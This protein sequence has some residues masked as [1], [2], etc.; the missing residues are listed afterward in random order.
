MMH[1]H[2]MWAE[3]YR[4]ETLEDCIM[5]AATRKEIESIVAKGE[6][7]SL[8]FAGSAGIGKTTVAIALANAVDYDFIKINGSLDNGIDTLR[9]DIQQF[10]S[11]VSFN[12]K[13]KVVIIDEADNLSQAMQKGLRGFIDEFSANCSF[14]L[15]ANFANKIIEPLQSRLDETVTFTFSLNEKNFL[16]KS[17]FKRLTE[18]FELENVRGDPAALREFVV[19]Q[20]Q[21]KN[22]IRAII[23]KAQAI[24]RKS[25][26]E[27]NN[28][29]VVDELDE[30]FVAMRQALRRRSFDEIRTWVG[31]NS[32]IDPSDIF[33]HIYENAKDIA[34]A[35]AVPQLVLITN[36]YQYKHAFVADAELN[37]VACLVEIMA[38]CI[39]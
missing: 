32:D 26:G 37:I 39:S 15:T 23:T 12:G 1:A 35:K 8:L 29:A 3:K 9:S 31:E 21:R 13:P 16:A 4:P 14:I 38:D 18:I 22:D 19:E 27:F 25:G 33:R 36:E 7:T 28:S 34:P 11:T 10:A 17:L 5:P 20:L 2:R 6:L 24:V 30:R